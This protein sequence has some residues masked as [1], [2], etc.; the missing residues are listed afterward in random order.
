VLNGQAPRI[1]TAHATAQSAL[2]R[3]A[4]ILLTLNSAR[5]NPSEPSIISIPTHSMAFCH[6][7]HYVSFIFKR[8]QK[9]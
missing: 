6:R 8:P 2:L 4:E 3:L 9:R 5:S 1:V 7:R